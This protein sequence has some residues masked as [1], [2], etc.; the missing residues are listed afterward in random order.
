MLLF[1]SSPA[2][3]FL[4]VYNGS[5]EIGAKEEPLSPISSGS[6]SSARAF[7]SSK[8][9]SCSIYP[10]CSPPRVT[11]RAS[12]LRRLSESVKARTMHAK[13]GNA[14]LKSVFQNLSCR[15]NE[16]R[17][18]FASARSSDALAFS[19]CVLAPLLIAES[20][21][22]IERSSFTKPPGALTKKRR[23][24]ARALF[25]PLKSITNGKAKM[26]PNFETKEVTSLIV[27]S[28][29]ASVNIAINERT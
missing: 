16:S 1:E 13:T 15:V 5:A 7:A 27:L 26:K 9:S 23:R 17:K 19:F 25:A 6:I 29:T 12:T 2:P 10:R 22:L 18:Y 8:V 20:S 14:V 4:R 28:P 11:S 3:T 24:C 21:S